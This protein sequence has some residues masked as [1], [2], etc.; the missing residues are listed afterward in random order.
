MKNLFLGC[1]LVGS[2][3]SAQTIGTFSS[4]APTAQTEQ[5]VIPSTHRF[6][7]IVQSGDTYTTGGGTLHEGFDFTCY[8]PISSSSTNGY[9]SLN[10]E[11]S[12]G[13]VSILDVNSL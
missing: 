9:V 13:A 12:P 1:F 8:V 6:Q 2:S 4:V 7:K 11:T 5:F 10:H 3:L